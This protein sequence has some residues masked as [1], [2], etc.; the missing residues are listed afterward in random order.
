MADPKFSVIIPAYNEEAYLPRLL[1]SIDA[2]RE[3]YARGADAVE[4][5]VANN[6]ST[7]QTA[8][9]AE[10]R[11]C[12]VAFVTKRT[13]AASRNG[14]AAIATGEI[15]CFIDA[16]SA[17]HPDSFNAIEAA[18]ADGHYIAGATGIYPERWSL[19]LLVTFLV[20]VPVV[21]L[22]GMDT[23]LVFCRRQDF[24]K[25]DGYDE[26]LLY[27]EDVK[28]L[29]TLRKL[30][31]QRGQ[32]LVRLPQVKALGSTRKFDQLGDWHYFALAL[33][34]LWAV[35]TGDDASRETAERYWYKPQR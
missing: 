12:R 16:D 23:G 35:L 15:L 29:W 24:E 6:A 11:G 5:I 10:S 1:D 22:T 31:R 26:A 34:G 2:A 20:A 32:T 13:I 8:E 19:G 21:L 3:N 17:I 33:K 14:G 7:D 25:I 18:F 27:A 30:G 9:I 4:V 28:F